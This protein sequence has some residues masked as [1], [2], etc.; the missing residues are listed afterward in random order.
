MKKLFLVLSLLTQMSYAQS[1]VVLAPSDMGTLMSKTLSSTAIN[2]T[3]G[4]TYATLNSSDVV[5]KNNLCL[6]NGSSYTILF[7][8]TTSSCS[9][10]VAAQGAV[11]G[12]NGATCIERIKV[13]KNICLKTES[14]TANAG[15]FYGLVW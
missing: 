9:A 2:P 12:N 10:S 5:G 3:F 15:M 14:A 13:K 11:L 6:I 1:Q 7:G 4:G 8:M